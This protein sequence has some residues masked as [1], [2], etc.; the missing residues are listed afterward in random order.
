[1]QED[2]RTSQDNPVGC[3]ANNVTELCLRTDIDFAIDVYRMVFVIYERSRELADIAPVSRTS[4]SPISY[5]VSARL[6]RMVTGGL[7]SIDVKNFSSDESRRVQVH[8]RV[9]DVRHFAHSAHR[10]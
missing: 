7:P 4:R 8:Y 6:N 9:H 10:M 2:E 3:I 5:G 1:V